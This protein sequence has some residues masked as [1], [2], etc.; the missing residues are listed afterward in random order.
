MFFFNAVRIKK[1]RC[2]SCG[3]PKI[4][5]YRSPYVV[6]DF[7]GSLTDIDFTVGMETWNESAFTTAAY[8]FQKMQI[9]S[10]CQ[11]ALAN[12]DQ[13][14]YYQLQKSFWDLYYRTFPA[15]LPPSIDSDKK[16]A[17]YLEICSVAS[18]ESAFDP[19]WQTY[20]QQQQV[21][22]QAVTFNP[23]AEGNKADARSFFA[24]TDFF[25][26]ITREGLQVFYRDPKFQIMH[27]LIP[28]PVH[29]KMKL[30]MFVQAWVP[31]LTSPDAARLLEITGFKLEYT[32]ISPPAGKVVKCSHCRNDLFVPQG[33]YKIFCESCRK[34]S[35]LS[36]SFFCMSCGSPNDVPD[37]P[38]KPID[39]KSCKVENRLIR[40][41]FG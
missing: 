12:G 7:C 24:L 23:T 3:A 35:R 39:C 29:L 34:M 1:F 20:G 31:Y 11:A 38:G 9:M 4:N 5:E 30:S 33:A 13:R 32:D 28:E 8:Q 37:N 2:L 25:I 16:Y 41:L 22:Q 10:Q 36:E 27:E 14:G 26:K 18:V 15:Y 21:L 40:P 17:I 19:K 6:C